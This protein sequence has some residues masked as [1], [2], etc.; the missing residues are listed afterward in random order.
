[1]R[2]STRHSIRDSDHQ[3]C[4]DDGAVINIGAEI[5]AGTMI[6]GGYLEVVQQLVKTAHRCSAIL[7]KV[8]LSPC[9]ACS[10]R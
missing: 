8:S 6:V 7:A 10:D 2:V 1:M 4:R 3:C 5:G 9:Q